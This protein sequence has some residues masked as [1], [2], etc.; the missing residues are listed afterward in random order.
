MP[1]H[2]VRSRVRA[3]RIC[4]AVV[5]A[6]TALLV[7]EVP[8]G[9]QK[10]YETTRYQSINQ[11][12]ANWT[13]FAPNGAP[14]GKD[15][16]CPSFPG[17]KRWS[18]VWAST[19]GLDESLH[20]DFRMQ[21]HTTYSNG[22]AAAILSYQNAG[23]PVNCAAVNSF[24]NAGAVSARTTVSCAMFS[25]N[26]PQ[27]W[28]QLALNNPNDPTLNAQLDQRCPGG[29]AN[30]PGWP[31]MW[32]EWHNL[33]DRVGNAAQLY[34]IDVISQFASWL[35]SLGLSLNMPV[36]LDDVTIVGG[37]SNFDQSSAQP[38]Y[39]N[40]WYGYGQ[41]TTPAAAEALSE[42]YDQAAWNIGRNPVLHPVDAHNAVDNAIAAGNH[43]VGTHGW[44]RAQLYANVMC[45]QSPQVS[46]VVDPGG[47]HTLAAIG[48]DMSGW[49][50]A[51]T[52]E[53]LCQKVHEQPKFAAVASAACNNTIV[54]LFFAVVD[55]NNCMNRPTDGVANLL[56][57]DLGCNR[58]IHLARLFSQMKAMLGG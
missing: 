6:T 51:E 17:I 8:A 26:R 34:K 45:P 33:P 27:R 48:E 4:V 50:Q 7:A 57:V 2:A 5:T 49:V 11:P 55:N 12:I 15:P 32:H 9:A 38:S 58:D 30:A 18:K 52:G 22:V 3:F 28:C 20:T 14:I 13:T 39:G 54:G 31:S 43:P 42:W 23:V 1:F 36:Y 56:G 46:S 47:M 35:S 37:V 25:Q 29:P 10:L 19:Y 40:A 44:T 41:I 21:F 16:N 24:F 53:T